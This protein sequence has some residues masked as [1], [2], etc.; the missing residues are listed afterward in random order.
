MSARTKPS[1][2]RTTSRCEATRAPADAG[3]DSASGSAGA[4]SLVTGARSGARKIRRAVRA[5]ESLAP[6]VPDE[7]RPRNPCPKAG[8]RRED[9]IRIRMKCA[10]RRRMASTNAKG[11]ILWNQIGHVYHIGSFMSSASSSFVLNTLR[12]TC[13]QIHGPTFGWGEYGGENA[14]TPIPIP[15]LASFR[16]RSRTRRV[17]NDTNRQ[18]PR[19]LRPG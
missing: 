9:F 12:T 17:S 14:A 5:R 8:A 15:H 16:E 18:K 6:P 4:A 3:G 13:H 1:R 11:R 7:S 2:D 19:S 10:R